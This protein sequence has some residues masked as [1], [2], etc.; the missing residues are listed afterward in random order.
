MSGA[1]TGLGDYD[2]AIACSEECLEVYEELGDVA[3]VAAC[4]D[5]S[6]CAHHAA[7]R[8]DQAARCYERGL[9]LYREVGAR[10]MEGDMLKKLGDLGRD[11]GDFPGAVAFWR[12]AMTIFDDIGYE[13]AEDVRAEMLELE[14]RR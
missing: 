14:A 10:L 13:A 4:W 1:Y 12:A 5:N 2:R 9:E 8:Y 3:G 11:T 6:G 7:G